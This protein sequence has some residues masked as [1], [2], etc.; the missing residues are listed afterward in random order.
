[1]KGERESPSI[2]LEVPEN[3]RERLKDT[4]GPVISGDLPS[5][6]LNNRPL[7]A[8]GDV[9]TERLHLQGVIPDVSII[10]EKTRRG[11]HEADESYE[12]ETMR[13]KNPSGIIAKEAWSTLERALNR[14]E[15]VLIIVDGEEDLLSLVSIALCPEGGTVIYG[16]PAEG[17]VINVVDDD[18]KEK[19]WQVINRMK[20][21]R[22]VG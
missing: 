17:M 2:D 21:V 16:I 4:L 13:V 20:K 9:V 15:P 8:V 3:L 5:E 10:D 7:I 18:K 1:M 6:Y 12:E 11:P 14:D 22:G 19:T